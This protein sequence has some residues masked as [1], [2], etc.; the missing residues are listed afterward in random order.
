LTRSTRAASFKED[1]NGKGLAA[2]FSFAGLLEM[3]KR[4][5]H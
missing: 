3:V 2:M 4:G 5:Y 1:A